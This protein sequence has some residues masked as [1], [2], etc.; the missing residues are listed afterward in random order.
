M[1]RIQP[2]FALPFAH[3]LH[4]DP[5]PLNTAL[6]QL[7]LDRESAGA[8]Y[9]NPGP[10]T[11]RNA[12]VFESHFHL[13]SWPEPEIAELREFCLGRV[14]QLACELNAYD[15]GSRARLRVNTDA[16]FHVTRRGGFFGVHNHPMATWSGVYC[17]STGE[18]DAGQPESGVLTFIHPHTAGAM[19]VDAGAEFIKSPFGI[20]NLSLSLQPGQ[21]VLF[22]SWILHQV[23]P[24]H[25]EGERI[26][27]AFNCSFR[28]DGNE[29][30][31]FLR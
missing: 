21:L 13:F 19:Y 16:W 11:V 14:V 10:Y 3:D 31:T 5:L 12:Q 25:G 17:V 22:P 28:L 15:A 1:L 18:N 9:A 23:L 20:G 30:A 7:F 26:S 24:F 4:P 29:P 8:R 6:R 2:M 27:V